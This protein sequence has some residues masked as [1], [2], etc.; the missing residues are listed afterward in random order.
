MIPKIIHY[1]WFGG[2][3]KPKL[4]QDC[5]A[6]WEKYCPDFEIKEWNESNFDVHCVKFVEDAF[7]ARK[8]AYV[9][10]YARLYAMVTEGGVYLDSDVELLQPIDRFLSEEAFTGFEVKDSPVTAI[11]GCEKGYPLFTELM[12]NYLR[13]EFYVNG[14]MTTSTNTYEITKTFEQK[15]IRLNGKKQTVC[16]CTVYPQIVFCPNNLRRVFYRYSPRSYAVHHFMGSWGGNSITYK[17]TFT[18]R[19]KML[20]I[21]IGRNL[22][23]TDRMYRISCALKG[24]RL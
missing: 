17:R 1:C 15:G 4:V 6:S 14:K 2:A 19:L 9:A 10:D 23:G 5:I 11:M 21:C 20:A 13:M 7:E 22:F 16:G 12:N 3:P 24:V 18:Q 8:W